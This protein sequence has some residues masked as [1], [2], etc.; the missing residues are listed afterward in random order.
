MNIIQFT[1]KNYSSKLKKNNPKSIFI[2]D[3]EF[4][5]MIIGVTLDGH[6]VYNPYVMISDL[7]YRN[8]DKFTDPVTSEID[9]LNLFNYCSEL[10]R[11]K[12]I[13]WQLTYID[14]PLCPVFCEDYEFIFKT[15]PTTVLNKKYFFIN[16]IDQD[17]FEKK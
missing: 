16:I 8:L 15:L 5:K 13:E 2:P 1:R 7:M 9:D 12:Q 14:E 4:Q 10:Q 17:L 3:K 6:I 11:S